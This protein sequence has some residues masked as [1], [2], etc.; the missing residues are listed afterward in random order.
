MFISYGV[1]ARS[2]QQVLH[3]QKNPDVGHLRLKLVWPFPDSAL[4]IFK[5]AKTFLVPELNLGQIA[6]EVQRHTKNEVV[7][8]PKL[9]GAL[10]SPAELTTVL[11]GYL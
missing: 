10:H 7:M 5:N 11:E 8:L 2:V 6:R 4:R 3:D 9:G 1:P